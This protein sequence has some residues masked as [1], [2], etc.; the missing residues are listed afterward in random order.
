MVTP[1][2]TV[3]TQPGSLRFLPCS[4]S[5]LPAL[6]CPCVQTQYTPPV[7]DM[8]SA[9]V[10]WIDAMCSHTTLAGVSGLSTGLMGSSAA[11]CEYRYHVNIIPDGIP[12]T[13]SSVFFT[14][15]KHSIALPWWIPSSLSANTEIM[16]TTFQLALRCNALLFSDLTRTHGSAAPK[17]GIFEDLFSKAH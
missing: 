9:P 5:A 13:S 7:S 6:C 14:F 12:L 1:P 4:T 10:L 16:S 8:Y 15:D 2:A 17:Y 11:I 3:S